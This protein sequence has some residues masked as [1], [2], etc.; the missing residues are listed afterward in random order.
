MNEASV[1][2][3]AA[4]ASDLHPKISTAMVQSLPQTEAA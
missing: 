4:F 2:I 1:M 3:S